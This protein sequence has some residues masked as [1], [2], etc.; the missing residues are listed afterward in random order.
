M[1]MVLL[2]HNLGNSQVSVYRTI[3]PTLVFAYKK[4][5]FSHDATHMS[6]VMRK[7]A[8]CICKN[9]GADQLR[10]DSAGNHCAAD[11]C[12]CSHYIDRTIP[13]F[14]KIRNFKPLAIFCGCAAQFES[15]LVRHPEDMF[16]RVT[17][18][19]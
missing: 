18:H 13:L 10:S 6:S 5:R 8:F 16:S 2:G 3:G 11:Q 12:L 7:P 19:I 14:P 4:R 1:V 15:D 9:K 17:A